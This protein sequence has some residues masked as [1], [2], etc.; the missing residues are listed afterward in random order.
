MP[1][2]HE[3]PFSS[4]T[5]DAI[6][7]AAAQYRVSPA[8]IVQAALHLAV[9]KLTGEEEVTLGYVP[10]GRVHAELETA[11]G[12]FV[13]S[14]PLRSRP[15]GDTSVAE[16]AVAIQRGAELAERW[17]DTAPLEPAGSGIGFVAL[18]I[19]PAAKAGE[20]SVRCRSLSGAPS[21]PIEFQWDGASCRMLVEPSALD[22]VLGRAHRALRRPRNSRRCRRA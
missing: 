7:A 10:G 3:V 15:A 21:F 4:Q 2:V 18:E 20:L 9:A 12:T 17:Q 22:R 13:R 16:L 6:A 8:A 19:P 5:R 14:L 1:E 11:V